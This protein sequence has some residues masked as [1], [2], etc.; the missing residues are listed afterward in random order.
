MKRSK[1]DG[2]EP[3]CGYPYGFHEFASVPEMPE[4]DCCIHCGR[5]QH[6][7]ESFQS[8]SRERECESCGV[9]I[10]IKSEKCICGATYPPKPYP[11]RT[12]Q[13]RLGIR[14]TK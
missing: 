5:P 12:C 11:Q 1:F 4:D 13:G 7:I 8:S 10:P 9:A 3:W 14:R 2:K 6:E